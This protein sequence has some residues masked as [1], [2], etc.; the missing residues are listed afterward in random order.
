VVA[1]TAIDHIAAV[2][3]V[4]RVAARCRRGELVVGA[5]RW[6]CTVAGH[7]DE[8]VSVGS[9]C[10][11]TSRGQEAETRDEIDRWQRDCAVVSANRHIRE[12]VSRWKEAGHLR[13]WT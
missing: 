10:G 8:I 2:E 6:R 3:T 7:V 12:G 13:A 5:R 9:G 1:R 4:Q 11:R